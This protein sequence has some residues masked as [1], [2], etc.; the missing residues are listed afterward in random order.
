MRMLRFSSLCLL[1]Q[2]ERRAFSLDFNSEATVLQAGN[3]LGKSAVLKSLYDS[4]GADPHRIDKAW[5]S[6]RVETLLRFTVDDVQYAIL[7]GG[8]RFSIFE[9][10]GNLIMRTTSVGDDLTSYLARLLDFQLKMVDKNDEVITPP[11]AYMFAPFYI[12]QDKSWGDPWVSFTR[13]YLNNSKQTLADY[14]SGLK[15]N[16][17]YEAQTRRSLLQAERK[18]LEAERLIVHQTLQSMRNL[19]TDVVLSYDMQDFQQ[20]TDQLLVES[21]HLHE[22][23]QAYRQ[24]LADISEERRLWLE[25]RDLVKAT[26][27]EMDDSFAAALEQPAD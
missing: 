2:H 27:A 3:G 11:P 18:N 8:N 14:H 15:P 9:G 24:K 19:V 12:D 5:R 25:Q 23:Q 10:G 7:K 21:R 22:H 20:A 16:A 26:L 1:S 4:F 17:Y 13:M 6:A